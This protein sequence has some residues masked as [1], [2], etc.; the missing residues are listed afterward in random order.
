[1][2]RRRGKVEP[3][4]IEG[5]PKYND[6]VISKFINCLM[7][8]GKKSVAEAVFYDALE[9][10]AKKTG[11]D[12]YQVFQEALENAKPQVEVKSRRVGGVTLPQFQSKFVRERR[13]ALGIRWLIRY[14]R[15]RNEKS[16]KNKLAAEFMEAQKGTGSA[17]KK[18]EDI[19]KMA[20]ANKAFS[21]YRW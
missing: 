12:P 1:M 21:H 14:S 11:Q 6:K 15:D 13:L 17:I 16:M 10:I 19:R 18:K 9:V 20:D 3:R 8:D 5:D 2:S 7:V 4:H